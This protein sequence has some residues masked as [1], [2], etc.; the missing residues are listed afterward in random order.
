MGI[1]INVSRPYAVL[2][3]PEVRNIIANNPRISGKSFEIAQKITATK[4]AHIMYMHTAGTTGTI[5][6]Y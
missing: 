3:N 4:K 1:R 5:K 6:G 2:Y